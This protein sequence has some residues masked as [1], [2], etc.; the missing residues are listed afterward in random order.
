M[1]NKIQY[2]MAIIF[3]VFGINAVNLSAKTTVV[4]IRKAPPDRKRV[5]VKPARPKH[6]TVWVSGHWRWNGNAYVWKE[7]HWL[8][9][10]KNQ[11]WVPGYWRKTAKGH[12]WIDGH[13]KRK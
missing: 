2:L 4:Y 9:A 12:V 8:K 5:V 6:S 10:R 11:K 1:K 7:G 13:W 3:V